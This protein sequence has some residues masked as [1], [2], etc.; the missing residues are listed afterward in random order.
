MY[1]PNYKNS[2]FD[3]GRRS[4]TTPE[5]MDFTVGGRQDLLRVQ[6][7]FYPFDRRRNTEEW[8]RSTW[9]QEDDA[10]LSRFTTSFY[11]DREVYRD[12]LPLIPDLPKHTIYYDNEDIY[13]EYYV[14]DATAL[15]FFFTLFDLPD[16]GS[17]YVQFLD[18]TGETFYGDPAYYGRKTNPMVN[19]LHGSVGPWVE[20]DTIVIYFHSDDSGNSTTPPEFYEGF[21]VS[22]VEARKPNPFL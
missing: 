16:D 4:Y 19:K 1:F 14:P 20:G 3:M 10:E 9:W 15:R 8:M 5:A 17:D 22:R 13:I 7:E 21:R 2:G 6:I 11:R 12:N 18:K